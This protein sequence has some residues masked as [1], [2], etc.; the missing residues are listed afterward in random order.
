MDKKRPLSKRPTYDSIPEEPI[1]R[2]KT[3]RQEYLEHLRKRNVRRYG[4]T[5]KYKNK[6]FKIHTALQVR[7]Y[8][9]SLWCQ[10]TG[11]YRSKNIKKWQLHN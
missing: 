2:P 4:H 1:F 11:N 7:S 8:F 5:S 6:Y 9:Q 10:I 3:Q